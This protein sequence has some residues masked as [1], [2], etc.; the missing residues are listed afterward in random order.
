MVNKND[1]GS[2]TSKESL[3]EQMKEVVDT[4]LMGLGDDNS[5]KLQGRVASAVST[6]FSAGLKPLMEQMC[7]SSQEE[8][9]FAPLKSLGG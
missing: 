5:N 6:A 9:Q 2:G 8:D 4:A 3:E 1:S 7:P